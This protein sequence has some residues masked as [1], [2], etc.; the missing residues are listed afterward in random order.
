MKKLLI[1]LF[2][3]AVLTSCGT[4]KTSDGASHPVSTKHDKAFSN[5]YKM[6]KAEDLKRN[7]YVIAS[8]EMEG[9]DTGSKGQKKAGEYI[10][11]YYKSLGISS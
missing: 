3:I 1:P 11:N 2:A 5:A 9:R 7:L 10:V 4:A 8:D 6:I